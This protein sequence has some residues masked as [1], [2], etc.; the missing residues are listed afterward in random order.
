MPRGSKPGERRGGR[1]KGTGNKAKANRALAIE[2]AGVEPKTFLLNGLA[3]YEAIVKRELAKGARANLTKLAAAFAA[4]REF[5]KDAAPYCHSRLPQAVQL[6]NVLPTDNAAEV[7]PFR[8]E[9]VSAKRI[10]TS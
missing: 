5:A 3:F 1:K 9:F 8:V 4:G 7:E 2:L 10:A 6:G